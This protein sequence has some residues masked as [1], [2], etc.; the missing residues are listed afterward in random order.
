M[1][2]RLIVLG[3]TLS[4]LIQNSPA[5][6]A[7]VAP[8][9]NTQPSS[10]TIELGATSFSLSVSAASSDGGTLSYQ[11]YRRLAIGATANTISNSTR[12][13][14]ATLATL[15]IGSSG[16]GNTVASGDAGIYYVIVTNSLAG[17]T[18][19]TTSSN[20][21]IVV[22][23]LSEDFRN[24]SLS[25]ASDWSITYNNST[26]GNNPRTLSPSGSSN[27]NEYFQPCLTAASTTPT[28][29]TD[30][31]TAATDGDGQ[32][33]TVDVL[34]SCNITNGTPIDSVG[35]GA[36]RL[37]GLRL[38]TR[39][40]AVYTREI[41]TSSGLDI[42]F[43]FA[44]YS[45]L[46]GSGT[47]GTADGSGFYLK[48]GSSTNYNPGGAGGAIGYAR[49]TT[50][51]NG[52]EAGLFAVGFDAYGNVGQANHVG[53]N[54]AAGSITDFNSTTYTAVAN[55]TTTANKI[56]VLGPTGNT[57]Q[58]GYCLLQ[59]PTGSLSSTSL[60]GYSAGSRVNM[61]FQNP[62]V[63]NRR[64]GTNNTCT[65]CK[66]IRIIVDP[67]SVS[68]PKI[69]VIVDGVVRYEIDQPQ[70][71]KDS[72]TFKFGFSSAT[73]GSSIISEFWGINVRTY[74][75]VTAPERP[76]AVSTAI[77]GDLD[78]S[79]TISWTA[80]SAWGIGELAST[81]AAAV[82]R[83]YVARIFNSSGTFTGISCSTTSTSCTVTGIVSGTNYTARVFAINRSGIA[84]LESNGSSA[85]NSTLTSS[86][87]ATSKFPVDPRSTTVQIKS[88]RLT[89]SST[90]SL[91]V[92][93]DLVTSN[94]STTVLNSSGAPTL[95]VASGGTQENSNSNRSIRIRGS[96]ANVRT[97]IAGLKIVAADSNRILPSGGNSRWLLI[98]STAINDVNESNLT[99][100]TTNRNWIELYELQLRRTRNATVTIGRR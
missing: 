35:N 92:C 87:N 3:L 80:P 1:K 17:N 28:T 39:A 2:N 60:S 93:I 42:S 18:S 61:S 25:N 29:V 98:R 26:Y 13:S 66:D 78:S 72:S 33:K 56:A 41:N 88:I 86:Q 90:P 55:V 9:I 69:F 58:R 24:T 20:A 81:D 31:T 6:F 37:S 19:T 10:Q 67:S 57:T 89:S 34:G 53:S 51:E 62:S 71:L 30:A 23:L 59:T 63:Q 94:E 4:L 22:N 85:F 96:F 52:V 74:S 70:A 54:C 38:D 49:R 14:G 8:T 27:A 5:L 83:S 100:S 64:S 79:R 21:S 11:W 50:T 36:L 45:G 46:E 77:S 97:A 68:T 84:S 16:V 82:A 75:G 15:T 76:T 7:A 48:R 91:F 95:S 32:T 43:G 12:I 99:C 73:G 65:V 47:G 44:S 40:S